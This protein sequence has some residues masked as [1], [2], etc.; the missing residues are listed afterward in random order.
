MA[1]EAEDPVDMEVSPGFLLLDSTK[2]GRVGGPCSSE[3]LLR[4]KTTTSDIVG[5]IETDD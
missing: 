1:L 5:L 2:V 4:S 3:P